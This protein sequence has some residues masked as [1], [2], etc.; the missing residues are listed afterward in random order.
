M[1]RLYYDVRWQV[2]NRIQRLRLW[3]HLRRIQPGQCE[4]PGCFAEG[5]PC[6]LPSYAFNDSDPFGDVPV[7][8]G[9]D[10]HY[11]TKHAKVNGFCWGCGNFF[12]GIES[13]D[14]GH[15]YGKTDGLC[16]E[17]DH[18]IKSDCGE[19]DDWDDEDPYGYYDYPD[20]AFAEAEGA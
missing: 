2:E 17:C 20:E 3:W 11:C 4:E 7:A 1:K 18:Q 12:G 16:D 19:L 10:H 6:F 13:F 14:F 5:V 9:P 15:A 8:A